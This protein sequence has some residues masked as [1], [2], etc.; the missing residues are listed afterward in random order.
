[1]VDNKEVHLQ[2]LRALFS[3]L[4]DESTGA[5]TFGDA[6]Q[7]LETPP[8]LLVVILT[9]HVRPKAGPAAIHII[10]NT[11]NGEEDWRSSLGDRKTSMSSFLLCLSDSFFFESDT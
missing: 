9:P 2:K 8:P 6:V 1:M 4:G 7:E 10:R 5:I 11:D 3:E